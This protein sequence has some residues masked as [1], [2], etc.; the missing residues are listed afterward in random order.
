MINLRPPCT[1]EDLSFSD[2]LAYPAV[3]RS[4]L[5]TARRKSPAHALVDKPPTKATDL[6]SLSHQM[7][8]QPELPVIVRPAECGKGTNAAKAALVDWI[9]SVTGAPCPPHPGGKIAEGKLLDAWLETL[10]P[11]LDAWD[12]G[13]IA[14]ADQYESACRMRDAVRA[15]P[16]AGAIYDSGRAEVTMVALDPESGVLVKIRIDWL[17]DGHSVLTDYKTSAEIWE[18]RIEYYASEWSCHFQ[19]AVYRHVYHLVT[20]EWAPWLNVYAESQAPWS[21]MVVPMAPDAIDRGTNAMRHALRI[22][23]LCEQ[24]KIWPGP[25]WD[26]TTMQYGLVTLGVRPWAI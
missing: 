5:D 21:V 10:E 14:T 4:Q 12:G 6:G 20:G 8:Q 16:L 13:L 2:Y 11:V 25:G 22:W 3:S 9:C 24:H 26:W 17:A 18:D 19:A 23:G 15:H 7:L 1:I